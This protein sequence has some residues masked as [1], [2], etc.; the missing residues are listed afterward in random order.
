MEQEE[1]EESDNESEEDED[2]EELQPVHEGGEAL[3]LANAMTVEPDI[4]IVGLVSPPLYT[5]RVFAVPCAFAC[6]RFV[7][8]FSAASLVARASL[9]DLVVAS[10]VAF[11]F[12]RPGLSPVLATFL[13]TAKV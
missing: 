4:A 3:A 12:S 7:P 1:N 10:A 11:R 13:F 9:W 8:R 5:T 6:F 2:V